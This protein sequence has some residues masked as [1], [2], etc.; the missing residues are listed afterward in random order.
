VKPIS[1]TFAGLGKGI[2]QTVVTNQD[3]AE[4]LDTS[5]EWITARTGIKSRRILE[6]DKALSY[7]AIKAGRQALEMAGL[8]A[9]DI[10][11]VIVATVT[12]D[13]F[14]PATACRVAHA[15]GCQNAGA[16]DLNIA[17]SGFLYGILTTIAQ[18]ESGLVQ[19]VLLIGGDT[20]SRIV[21]WTDRRTA[22]LFGDC[23]GAAVL[24]RRG[25]G[26]ILG[27]DYGAD[28]SA[29]SALKI[30]AGPSNPSDCD[31]D[32]KVTMD[33]RAVFRFA[34]GAIVNSC[35]RSLDM[36][37]LTIDDVDLIIPHQANL[38]II[39]SA[40]KKLRCPIDKFFM[41]LDKYGNTSAGSIPVALTEAHEEGRL[42]PGSRVLLT[43]F[44][45]GLSWGSVLLGW[46]A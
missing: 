28:G 33:G 22:V 39:E 38:R 7:L 27:Y 20:L 19:N 5:D 1:L 43:G 23:A 32:Y 31:K 12:P 17:C 15:L 16:F 34:A 36:A 46:P 21:D 14:M 6:D 3:L 18:M 10:D 37:G 9:S 40:A 13:T 25:A 35:R 26:Q 41:N 8:P 45:G 30:E 11:L 4:S 42:Q 29:G 24:T 44:G 2:P